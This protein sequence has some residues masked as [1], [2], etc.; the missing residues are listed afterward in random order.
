MLGLSVLGHLV[1]LVACLACARVNE[2]LFDRAI[3]HFS[4]S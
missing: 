3:C 1:D 4:L 2:S